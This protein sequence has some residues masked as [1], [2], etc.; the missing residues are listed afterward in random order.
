M[1]ILIIRTLLQLII[2][3][4]LIAQIK[5]KTYKEIS[6]EEGTITQFQINQMSIAS[7]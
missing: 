4:L 7:I 6:K 1:G 5:N 3:F 2:A